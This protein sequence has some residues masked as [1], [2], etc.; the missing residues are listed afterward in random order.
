MASV[1]ELEKKVN[2]SHVA[3]EVLFEEAKDPDRARQL[4]I[5][6]LE[7]EMEMIRKNRASLFRWASG[8]AVLAVLLAI[9]R[10]RLTGD[11]PRLLVMAAVVVLVLMIMSLL[12]QIRRFRSVLTDE[13]DTLDQIRAGKIDPADFLDQFRRHKKQELE[14]LDLGEAYEAYRDLVT[15]EDK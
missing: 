1:Q 2:P 13:Q 12:A 6:A 14:A 9:L 4:V 11:T 5:M 8:G 15:K 7:S 3:P 10:T